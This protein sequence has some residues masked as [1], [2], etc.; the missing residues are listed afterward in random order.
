MAAEAVEVLIVGAGPA[1]LAAGIALKRHGVRN[2]VI[3]EREDAPGGTPRLC[4]HTGF[5][6]RDLRGVFSGPGYARHYVRQAEAAGVEIRTS[7]TV[8]GWSG[9]TTAAFTSPRGLGTLAAQAVLLATGCRERPRS[10]RLIPGRRPAGVLTTGSLQ[11]FVYQQRLP[12]GRRAVIVGAELVSLSAL[13]T[14]AHAGVATAAILTELP[15]HQIYFPYLPAKWWFAD[16]A[17]RVPVLT[18]TRV[19]EIFGGQ[20]VAGVEITQV[21]AGRSERLA[22]DTVV[23]TGDWI[24]EHELARLGGLALDSGTRGPSVDAG[25]HTS[26]RGVFAAGNLLRGAE[27]ADVCAVEGAR[28]ARSIHAFLETGQWPA[29]GRP[30]HVEPPLTWICPNVVGAPEAGPAAGFAFRVA[31]FCHQARV[32][33]RQGQ[34]ELFSQAFRRLAP[35]TSARLDSRWLPAVDPAGETVRVGL[36]FN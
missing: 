21:A 13:M 34:T 27:T 6:L 32:T 26:V 16:L 12:V 24:P 28:A 11:R 5:G 7:T 19:S 30:V 2:V 10:A 33:V 9:P 36:Q 18:E 25:W 22:C 29:A 4:H 35:N 23:F 14:L 8:T 1:G 15:H 17:A 31:A 3:V 20:R